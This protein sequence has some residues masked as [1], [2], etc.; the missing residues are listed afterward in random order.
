MIFLGA[1][2]TATAQPKQEETSGRVSLKENAPADQSPRTPEDW[3]ELASPTPA[4]HGTEYV[5]VGK[6]QGEF[7]QLRIDAVKGAIPVKA[8][9]VEM[10]DG[11]VKNFKLNKRID[12][13][14]NK[15]LIIDLPTSSSIAHIVVV[16]DRKSTGEY[17]VFGAGAGGTT[18]TGV[19]AGR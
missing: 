18:G 7:A 19:V 6:D 3:V 10:A 1:V 12:V 16:T 15:S 2:G 17:S 4:K 13:K 8:V 14:R 11:S 9:A 5:V